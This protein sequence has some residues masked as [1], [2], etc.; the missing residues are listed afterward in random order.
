MQPNERPSFAEGPTTADA[1]D[2]G[3]LFRTLR[4]RVE[5]HSADHVTPPR[6]RVRS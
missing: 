1:V 2:P 6:V 3:A 5:T 4:L